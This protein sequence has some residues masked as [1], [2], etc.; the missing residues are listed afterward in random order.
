MH[1][2]DLWTLSFFKNY[3]FLKLFL[4]MCVLCLPCPRA[5]WPYNSGSSSTV[6]SGVLLLALAT[7][8][9]GARVSILVRQVNV[10]M[11]CLR[12]C[13]YSNQMHLYTPVCGHGFVG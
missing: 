7:I 1:A 3:L 11:Q 5:Y 12:Y 8:W 9:P 13:S 10:L 4:P 2:C 6:D